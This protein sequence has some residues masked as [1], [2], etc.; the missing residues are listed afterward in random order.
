[1]QGWR[2]CRQRAVG[3]QGGWAGRADMGSM[4]GGLGNWCPT[5]CGASA[6]PLLTALPCCVLLAV[7]VCTCVVCGVQVYDV[8]N[9]DVI[10]ME[11][12]ALQTINSTYGP[13]AESSA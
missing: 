9:A 3:L 13:A 2:P 6:C 8:L 1:M 11:K 10:V 7:A 12:S 4:A 5:C